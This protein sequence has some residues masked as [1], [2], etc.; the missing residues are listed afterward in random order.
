MNNKKGFTLIEILVVV[1]IISILS[2]IA[3]PNFLQAQTRSKVSRVKSDFRTI[4]TALEAYAADHN[5]FPRQVHT[6]WY[7]EDWAAYQGGDVR[8]ILWPG[9]TSP[10]AYISTINYIDPL[11]N[12]GMPIDQKY[13]T[14]N[15]MEEYV[16]RDPDTNWQQLLEYYGKWRLGSVGPDKKFFH[17]FEYSSQLVYDPSNGTISLGNIWRTQKLPEG[18]QPPVG[19]MLS[20]H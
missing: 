9:I 14:Y 20:E 3:I 18:N 11:A 5:D 19:P 6:E 10:I 17:G 4:A 16:V 15:D 12:E 8:G 1:A 13:Y 2:A 7:D